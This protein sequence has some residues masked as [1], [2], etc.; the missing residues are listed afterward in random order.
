MNN[1]LSPKKLMKRLNEIK[2]KWKCTQCGYCCNFKIGLKNDDWERWENVIVQSKIGTFAMRDFCDLESKNYSKLGDLFFHPI[3]KDELKECPF[4]NEKN[5]K[6]FCLIHDP[7]IKPN[8][9]KAFNENFVDLRCI[10][11]REIIKKMFG[12]TFENYKDES[13]FFRELDRKLFKFQQTKFLFKGFTK[14]F[15]YFSELDSEI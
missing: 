5:G 2:T 13:N 10:N 11:T 4:R 12:L 14:L 9:C 1:Y 3:T 8:A 7:K 6:T 15:T